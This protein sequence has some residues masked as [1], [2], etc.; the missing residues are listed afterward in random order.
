MQKS[1]YTML[2]FVYEW[3]IRHT[4]TYVSLYQRERDT[5]ENNEVVYLQ[6]VGVGNSMNMGGVTFLFFIIWVLE[7][8]ECSYIQN[9]KLNQKN[10]GKNCN[11]KQSKTNEFNCI[12]NEYK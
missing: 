11:W 4:H 2:S 7:A 9:T 12:S 10:R 5:P 3:K 8:Y 6:G 1:K